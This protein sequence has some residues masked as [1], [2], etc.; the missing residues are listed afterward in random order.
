MVKTIMDYWQ[1]GNG[2]PRHDDKTY[3]L[4]KITRDSLVCAHY[5][6]SA[7]HVQSGSFYKTG[8][9]RWGRAEKKGHGHNAAP[10]GAALHGFRSSGNP[11][12]KGGHKRFVSQP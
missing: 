7:T 2:I 12:L 3:S 11:P 4:R 1:T 6:R 10:G 5:A 9:R 8:I